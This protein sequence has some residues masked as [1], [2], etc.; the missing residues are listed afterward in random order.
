MHRYLLLTIGVVL[1]VRYPSHAV[2]LK[3]ETIAA[4]N[5][6]VQ[7]SE[8]RM[9]NDLQSGSFLW[10]EGLPIQQGEGLSERLKHGEVVIQKLET[11]ERGASI[12]VPGGLIHHWLGI[13]FIPGATLKQTMALLQ[14]VRWPFANLRPACAPLQTDPTHGR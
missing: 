3:P 12:S 13:V 2:E 11:L 9:R 8:Q 14:E 10:T 5:H 7:L 6:Y 1:F 4:F